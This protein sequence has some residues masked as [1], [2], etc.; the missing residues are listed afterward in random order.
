MKDRLADE[1][2]RVD[3]DNIMGPTVLAEAL[4]PFIE[5]ELARLEGWKSEAMEVLTKWDEVFDAL[6]KPG[7]LGASKADAALAEVNRRVLEA[8][9]IRQELEGVRSELADA[10]YALGIHSGVK[11][12][13]EGIDG[14]IIERALKAL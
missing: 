7:A 14:D 5:G 4:T 11:D 3:E 13:H 1:I 2:R 9:R 8:K 10:R 12:G 6:D